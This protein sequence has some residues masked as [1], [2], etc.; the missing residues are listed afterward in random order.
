MKAGQRKTINNRPPGILKD[1]YEEVSRNGSS[2]PIRLSLGQLLSA[3]ADQPIIIEGLNAK[4][5]I[6][7]E[8]IEVNLELNF[9]ESPNSEGETEE[10]Y[11]DP[12]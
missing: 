4:L 6:R 7:L 8:V 1:M 12:E 11:D 2:E 10:E 5:I 3:F 9:P